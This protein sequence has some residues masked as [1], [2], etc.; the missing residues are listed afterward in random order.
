[1]NN[2][3]QFSNKL[4]QVL[5]E[6]RAQVL[7]CVF[8]V[9]LFYYNEGKYVAKKYRLVG[10]NIAVCKS[11]GLLLNQLEPHPHGALIRRGTEQVTLVDRVPCN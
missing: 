4:L 10:R 7:T 1:M 8:R 11:N 3:G 5:D 9:F 6:S 2:C